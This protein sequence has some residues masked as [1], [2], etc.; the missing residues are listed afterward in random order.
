MVRAS[1]YHIRLRASADLGIFANPVST[2]STSVNPGITAPSGAA[3]SIDDESLELSSKAM[4][5]DA[6]YADPSVERTFTRPAQGGGVEAFLLIDGIQCGGCALSIEKALR[7][8][9]GVIQA[10]VN[11]ATHRGHVAWDPDRLK[12]A[13]LLRAVHETGYAA[14]PYDPAQR[15]TALESERRGRLRRLGIA[16]LFG[17][18]VMTLSIALYAGDYS[19]MDE[20]IRDLLRWASLLLVLPVLGYAGAP[21]FASAFRDLRRLRAGMDVPVSLGLLIAFAGSVHATFTGEGAVYFDSVVMFVFLLL[22]ARYVE[23][24]TRARH[25]RVAE[26]L[27]TAPPATAVRIEE[28]ADGHHESRVIA[29]TLA[30]GERVFVAAG[31]T[32]PADGLVISGCSTV[33]ESLLTGESR[34]VDRSVGD[35]VIA[36]SVNFDSPLEVRVE[37]AADETLL[38]HTMRL[39]ERARTMK[40]PAEHLADRVASRFVAGVLILAAAVAAYWWHTAPDRWLAVTIAVLVVSC[41]CALSLATPAALTAAIGALAKHGLVV[42]QSHALETLARVTRF[43]FDK[44]GTLTK[45]S[46]SVSRIALHAELGEKDVIGIAANLER[47]SNHPVGRAIAALST[48]ASLPVTEIAATPGGGIEGRIGGRLYRIGS[49]AYVRGGLHRDLPVDDGPSPD[50]DTTEVLLSDESQV[51]AGFALCDALRSDAGALIAKL[52]S[53]GIEVSLLSGDRTPTARHVGASLGIE[54]SLG[55]LRPP[56]KLEAIQRMQSQGEIVA[57]AGDG[58]NDAPVLAGADISV[59]MGS[60]PEAARAS[61]DLILLSDRLADLAT[62]IAIARKGRRVITQ[63]FAWAIAYNLIAL[64]AAGAGLVPP[65]LAALGMSLSSLVVVSNGLRAGRVDN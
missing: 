33:D 28:T 56:D 47:G 65:W 48:D 1:A 59:A 63:N 44:T 27:I 29:S 57:M 20:W 41:P 15:E 2:P 26:S 60:G 54:T 14:R 52:Q 9:T 6:A 32:V 17:M 16:G 49:A 42:T 46:L 12:L 30:P 18:Q 34:P 58:I 31:E 38:A 55:D 53:L 45:G 43:V 36:G 23:F 8:L 62:G 35:H 7:T 25:I 50:D 64:P 40:P 51:L 3:P 11:F 4:R 19:G 22:L 10:E 13:D 24:T 39:V 61:A 21:F 5:P 37:R